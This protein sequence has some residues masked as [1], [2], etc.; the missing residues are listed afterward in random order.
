ML[1]SK[2]RI[3]ELVTNEG[4]LENFD[5]SSL[6]GA[7][8]D[9]RAN[10]FYRIKGDSFLGVTER[11]LPEIEELEG[12][13]ITLKA[14]EYILVET[15]EKVHM[16][17]NL[18]ARIL[19]RSTLFRSGCVLA[20]AVVDP[21]YYGIL[22]MGLKNLSDLEFRIEKGARVGQITFEEV[23]GETELYNGKY[24]GGKIV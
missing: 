24:Q 6:N 18:M 5:E 2:Q 13:V 23:S 4:L 11:H 12:D 17:A 22:T 8:Y 7:G 14:G 16:P 15:L 21:G 20:T 10:R 3:K 1:L 19:S 9:L